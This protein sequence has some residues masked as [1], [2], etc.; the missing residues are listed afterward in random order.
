MET[1]VIT[2]GTFDVFHIGHI[3][4]LERAKSLGT[5][6]TVGV[7]S[8]E[9][10]FSKK[11]RYPIYS[12]DDRAYIISSLS[13]VDSV[14]LEQSLEL[15]GEYIKKYQADILV[16]GD[17]WEGRFDMY[18]ELCEV[19]YL[20]RTPSISTTEIIEIARAIK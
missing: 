19:I 1:R 20:P 17:D 2:F 7:S 14:F 16:M 9:L 18:K 13:C 15:K 3:K 6:L 5:H 12:Q 10:N 4:I 8:D 11:N